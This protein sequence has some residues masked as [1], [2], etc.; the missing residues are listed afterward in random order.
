MKRIDLTLSAAP[1][2]ARAQQTI[3]GRLAGCEADILDSGH[4]FARATTN[5]GQFGWVIQLLT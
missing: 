5:G 2:I 3:V 4:Q 1:I